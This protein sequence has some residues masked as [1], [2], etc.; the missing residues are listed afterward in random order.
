[1][2]LHFIANKPSRSCSRHSWSIVESDL[3]K[4]TT[5]AGLDLCASVDQTF[6]SLRDEVEPLSIYAVAFRYPGPADPALE[7][8]RQATETVDLVWKH[9]SDRLGWIDTAE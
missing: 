1:M 4:F 3:K 6:E 7:Q 8:I 5:L 2:W 9:V